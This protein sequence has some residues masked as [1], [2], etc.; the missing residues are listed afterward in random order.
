MHQSGYQDRF[1]DKKWWWTWYY[2]ITFVHIYLH[3]IKKPQHHA[4]PYHF[5]NKLFVYVCS[6]SISFDK[7]SRF[8]PWYREQVDY[9][10]TLS[11]LLE[12]S[13]YHF[14]YNSNFISE[15]TTAAKNPKKAR[16]Q[17]QLIASNRSTK[18]ESKQLLDYWIAHCVPFT[19]T[20]TVIQAIEWNII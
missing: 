20:V 8:Q 3:Q 1:E 15:T 19:D 9:I 12:L 18:V 11:H 7:K 14:S 13:G 2:D 4:S 16:T 17:L 6:N 5:K 10:S